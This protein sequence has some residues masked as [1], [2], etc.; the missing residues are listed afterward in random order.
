VPDEPDQAGHERELEDGEDDEDGQPVTSFERAHRGTAGVDGG[1]DT[2][3]D[4]Q[5]GR[6]PGE[7]PREEG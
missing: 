6:H 3:R 7:D 2:A 4:R 1:G 5:P